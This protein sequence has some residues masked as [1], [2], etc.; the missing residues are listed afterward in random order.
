MFAIDLLA[1]LVVGAIELVHRLFYPDQYKPE[2]P[3][4]PEVDTNAVE[5]LHYAGRS[6]RAVSPLRPVGTVRI[7]SEQHTARTQGEFIDVG[8]LVVVLRW[9]AG[10][11]IV[12]A[13]RE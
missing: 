6:G 5:S 2:P 7:D 13:V 3:P 11:L 4:P 1:I 9:A 8:Q 10:E 12:E